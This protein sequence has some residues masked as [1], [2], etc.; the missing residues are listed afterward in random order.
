MFYKKIALAMCIS[1]F[2]FIVSV[3]PAYANEK[4]GI[5]TVSTLNVRS[6]PDTNYSVVSK[7]YKGNKVEI[8]ESSNGWNKIKLI[9]GNI[10]W[11]SSSYIKETSSNSTLTSNS[12]LNTTASNTRVV[13]VSTLNVRSGPSTKNGV[14]TKVYKGNK[15]EIL[16][17]SNGWNKIKLTNSK[18]GWVNG[19]YLSNS[20]SNQ[21]T[22][23]P[24][25]NQDNSSNS[26]QDNDLIGKSGTITVSTLNVR[27]GPSTNY[28]IISKTYKGNKVE[29]LE[30]KNGW[31]KIKLSNSK[32]GWSNAKYVNLLSS[33]SNSES[34]SLNNNTV[35]TTTNS[36]NKNTVI[37]HA[38]NQL[39]KPYSW[40]SSGPNSFDC[41]GLTSYVYKQV[42][43]NLPR[44]SKEQY[45]V[46]KS[47]NKS[48]LMPGD[49]IFTS[50]DGTGNITHVG[51]YVGD[52]YMIH[53]PKPGDVVKKTSINSSY[54]K[55]SYVGDKRVL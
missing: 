49:L 17:S 50:S 35:G 19:S 33:N 38:S 29:V 21:S 27:S 45:N 54:Y 52:G 47:V 37:N 3:A 43:V 26:T 18:V 39:G 15:V 14:V 36:N 30:S 55:N 25:N 24:S 4:E 13:T 20:S 34:S 16:E 31:V 23:I 8:L 22:S 2:G 5:V 11:S 46:G 42:G 44:T 32:V 10:G 41:S 48:E 28:G 1:T 51:I 7:V 9:N 6:G 40:G 53:S 12:N